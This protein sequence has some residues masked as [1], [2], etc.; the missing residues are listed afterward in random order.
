MP[1]CVAGALL[2]DAAGL[3]AGAAHKRQLQDSLLSGGE[4]RSTEFSVKYVGKS[5]QAVRVNDFNR[6]H[7]YND[8]DDV[9][10]V[11]GGYYEY[12]DDDDH[13]H[14]FEWW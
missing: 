14:H 2:S 8:T 11:V 1:H 7:P 5:S 12:S 6:D 13:G 3:E 9:H 10:D 4:P